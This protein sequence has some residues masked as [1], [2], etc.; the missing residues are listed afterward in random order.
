MSC[1]LFI[2]LSPWTSVFYD[3]FELL[4]FRQA[5]NKGWN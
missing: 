5:S 2:T 1:Y 4:T 3:A